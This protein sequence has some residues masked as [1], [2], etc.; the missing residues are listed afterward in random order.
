MLQFIRVLVIAY[1]DTK[2]C[3]AVSLLY[4]SSTYS[5]QFAFEILSPIFGTREIYEFI[6]G[7]INDR[8]VE[9]K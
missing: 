4:L 7:K 6:K 5:L 8:K 2:L 9:E 1:V 3:D